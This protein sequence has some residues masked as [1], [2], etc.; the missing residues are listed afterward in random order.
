MGNKRKFFRAFILSASSK[1]AKFCVLQNFSYILTPDLD[2]VETIYRSRPKTV[3]WK[4]TV[5]SRHMLGSK[6][7]VTSH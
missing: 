3:K 2:G 1:A 7:V 4:Y 5:P 6:S